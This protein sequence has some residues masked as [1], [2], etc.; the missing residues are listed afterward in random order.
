M[1]VSPSWLNYLVERFR[2]SEFAFG[3]TIA[4]G[5]GIAAGLGAVAFRWLINSFQRLFFDGG[6][7]I[8]SFL[9][10][11]YVILVPVIGGIIIGLLIHFSGTSEAKGHGV[12]EVMEAVA[13]RGGRIR[14]R[15]AVVK[16]F[17][18]SICIGSG[19]SVGR[20]GPIVQIGSTIGSILGQRLGLPAE[21][22]KTLV[23]CGAAGGIS[24]TF[25]APIAGIFFAHEVIL[26]RIFTRHFGFVVIASVIADVIAHAFLGNLQSFSVPNYAL[27]TNWEL[28]LYFLMGAACA[29]VAIIFTRLLY[30]MEDI[31][32][33]VRL[34]GY[35]KPALG[36]IAVGFIG[37][38][39][40]YL[41]GVGYDGVE[42]ALL[43][44]IGLITLAVLLVLKILATS[45]TLGSGGSGGVFAPSLFMGAMF[46]GAFGT[47]ANRLFPS[48]VAPPGAFA[49]VGM[50]AVFSAASR[51]PITAI[52]IVFEMTGNYAIIL[53]LMM[54][55]VIS[56]FI[57]QRLSPESIYTLKLIR[58]GVDVHPQEEV[59]I[60]EKISVSDVMTSSFPSVSPEM[61]LT[62][63]ANMFAK[64]GHHG[65]PVVDKAGHLKGVVT[66]ADLE[67]KMTSANKNLTAADIATTNLITA[68]P[69]ESLHDVLHKLGDSEVGRIPV[70]DRKEPSK[71]VGVLRRHDFI[72]AYTK[73]Q[74]QLPNR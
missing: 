53:P 61:N 18:S 64:S 5:L 6:A 12:P 2:G 32:D 7:I 62:E 72:R 47:L 28:G 73:A 41:F 14:S 13:V 48:L 4:V 36:G 9:G 27:Q 40:P 10:H 16:I 29:L 3:T 52:I 42:Q 68:Y 35:L 57:A 17:A 67:A 43:G 31:F 65:F 60:L 37:L 66:V 11:Y 45:F 63:L 30:K 46:G 50:A 58:R 70:V 56:T 33:A 54:A 74:S 25:N 34:P 20:E 22:I 71:L 69:D 1:K 59:D 19:G 21:W 55:V 44:K 23:A 39:S 15:V 24:A 51:A 26:G 8:L 38:Y 49:L